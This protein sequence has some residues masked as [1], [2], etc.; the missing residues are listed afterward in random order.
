MTDRSPF[1]LHCRKVTVS[2]AAGTFTVAGLLYQQ[3]Q[4][5]SLSQGYC[6]K[7]CRYI[8]FRRVTV[9]TAAGTFTVAGL[10]YQQ[11]QVHSLSQGYCINSCRYTHYRR[12]TI[13]TAAGTF[14]FDCL[15][16]ITCP[17]LHKWRLI[18]GDSKGQAIGPYLHQ[19]GCNWLLDAKYFAATKKCFKLLKMFNQSSSICL[20]H[21]AACGGEENINYNQ[22]TMCG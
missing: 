16:P 11:L 18:F 2:T 7:S 1:T 4:V 21:I 14:T 10:L 6:I 13:S 3:L 22:T 9:S 5:H 8:R 19:S 15:S 20:S 17:S 12:V